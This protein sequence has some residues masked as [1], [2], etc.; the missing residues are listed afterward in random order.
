MTP[1]RS[2]AVILA[3]LAVMSGAAP[4]AAQWTLG[5]GVQSPRFTGGAAEPATGRSLVPYRPTMLEL[6]VSRNGRHVGVSLRGHYASSSLALEGSDGLAAV[7]DALSVYGIEPQVSIAFGHVGAGVLR[8][9]VGPLLEVWKFPDVRSHVRIGAAGSLE[10]EVPF[11]ERW[12]GA[13]RLG[14][15][16]SASPFDQENLLEGLEVRTLWRR[17]AAAELRFRL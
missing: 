7:K 4:A 16:A 11:G 6:S 15:A 2:R 17:A 13:L 1:T 3:V 5:A 14:G 8:A 9:L 12:S 10:L